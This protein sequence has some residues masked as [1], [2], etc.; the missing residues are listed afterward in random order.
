MPKSTAIVLA[1]GKG[2]RMK[3]RL[4]K[5]LHKICGKAMTRYVVDAC[6]TGGV[7]DCI[8]VVG[9]EAEQVQ[10]GLGDDVRYAIQTEQLGTGDACKRAIELLDDDS[11]SDVLVT[12][13]DTPLVDAAILRTLNEKHL[14]SG[15]AATVLTTILEDAGNYGRVLRDSSGSV[16]RI[17]E[18]KDASPD[19]RKVGEINAG[20]YC[21]NLP[22]LRKYLSQLTPVNAQGE[23]YLTDVIGMMVEAGHTVGAVVSEDQNIVLGANNRV[24]LAAL[25]T[26][27]RE[28]ILDQL[29]VDGVTIIDPSS[30]HVDSGVVIGRDSVVYPFSVIEGQ[31]RAGEG[32][33]IG[34]ST[35]LKNVQL[36]DSVSI[37]HSV[38]ESSIIGSGTKIGPFANIRSGCNIGERVK[39]GNFVEAKN[40]VIGDSVSMAHL[41]YLGD[42]EVGE[43][44]NIGAGSITCNYDGFAK[45]KTKIGKQVFLGS[46]T[47]LVA[48]VNVGD[49]SLVAAGSVITEDV[50]EN[51]L[52]IARSKQS[53]KEDWA[54]RRREKKRQK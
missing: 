36:G 15:A 45:H 25:T 35:H 32:C 42:A 22:L 41:S 14:A 17:V 51:A 3:S 38:A 4:P 44:S 20:I 2:T 13:G 6:K 54:E 10:A 52:A 23:Y 26:I 33:V 39:L 28:K 12:P 24:D 5:A 21:F 46:N 11:I 30:T 27:M 37:V 48:P 9:H 43:G 7:E 18:A 8:V 29:M 40:S 1:G 34:P 16:L 49:G 47:T 53:V 50:P 19:E 31:T